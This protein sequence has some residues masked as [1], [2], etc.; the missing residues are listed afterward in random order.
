MTH[1][2]KDRKIAGPSQVSGRQIGKS[3]DAIRHQKDALHHKLHKDPEAGKSAEQLDS[4]SEQ[5]IE[6]LP[7]VPKVG[8]RDAP[9]G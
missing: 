6:E 1:D 2:N 3:Q 9:G 8:S 7:E 5:Q 4:D